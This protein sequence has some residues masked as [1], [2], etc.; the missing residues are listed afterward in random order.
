MAMS[1]PRSVEGDQC[2]DVLAGPVAMDLDLGKLG[3]IRMNS[4]SDSSTSV[5]VRFSLSAFELV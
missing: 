5:A 1:S 3:L 4:L 2:G